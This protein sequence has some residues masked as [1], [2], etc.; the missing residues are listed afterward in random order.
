MKSSRSAIAYLL[1]VTAADAERPC[2]YLFLQSVALIRI[3]QVI[4]STCKRV[5]IMANLNM[6]RWLYLRGIIYFK[7]QPFIHFFHLLRC[8]NPGL[9]ML[10]P[11]VISQTKAAFP[12]SSLLTPPFNDS[13]PSVVAFNHSTAF[14]HRS[15]A[16][17]PD[18]TASS[19]SARSNYMTLSTPTGAHAIPTIYGC[20][21]IPT[22]VLY[23]V[24]NILSFAHSL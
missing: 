14:Y 22:A 23:P 17:H 11:A 18:P 21:S 8:L 10:N 7:P 4:Q 5:V 2:Y 20:L 16:A 12:S 13:F 15:L 3:L 24:E 19:R 9:L 6:N 1:L